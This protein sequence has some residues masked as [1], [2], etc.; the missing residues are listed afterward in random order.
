MSGN[1]PSARRLGS[2]GRVIPGVRV[3]IDE[4]LGD[5]PGRGEIIVYGPNVMKGYHD[6]PEENAK[7]FTSDG[8]F[9]TGDLGYVDDDG[10]L[11]ITGRIKEQYKLENGKYVMPSPLEERL[12]ISPF[13]LNAML[14]GDNR[15]FNVALI[16]ID[17]MAVR[18]WAER[19]GIDLGADPTRHPRVAAL[20]RGE[21]D[22][23]G[24]SFRG[25]ELPRAFVLTTEDFTIENG[26]LTPSLKLK[27]REAIARHGSAL[28]ALYRD[29]AL[30]EA[31]V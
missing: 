22:R 13:I 24:A 9:R 8:G 5:G 28:E 26:L 25:Y 30:L 3:V 21:I 12:K 31:H 27:R 19:E 10:F 23:E 20:V 16:V 2:V 4:S 7:A 14:Y 15:P 17:A 6:R 11:F 1:T 29:A 18:G